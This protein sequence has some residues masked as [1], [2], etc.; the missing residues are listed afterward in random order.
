ME[1]KKYDYRFYFSVFGKKFV[2]TISAYNK[3]EANLL[4]QK[5]LKEQTV[6][7]EIKE[8]HD[9]ELQNIKNIFGKAGLRI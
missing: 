2:T 5:K 4:F 1:I 8:P 7:D 6:I 3:N 9:I